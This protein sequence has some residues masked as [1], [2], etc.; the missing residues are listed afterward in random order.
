MRRIRWKKVWKDL[1]SN[2]S[3]TILVVLS[4]AVGVIAIGMVLGAQGI[5]DRQ[6][7]RDFMAI[8]PAAGFTITV[9]NFGDEVVEQIEDLESVGAAEGRRVLITPF[10]TA[11]GEFR[12]LQLVAVP[13]FE[14]IKINKL[15][16]EDGKYPPEKGEILIERS[17]LAPNL[18]F[19]GIEIGDSITVK[20]PNGKER[21]LQIVGTAHDLNNF[22]P[23]LFQTAYGYVSFD[24]MELLQE[25]QEYNQLFYTLSDEFNAQYDYLNLTAAES[26][27]IQAEANRVGSLIQEKIEDTGALVIFTLASPPGELPLQTVLDGLST[28]LLVMGLLSLGL[29]VFLIVNTLSAILTQQVRQIGIMKS[30]GARVPQLTGMYFFMVLI[31][32]VLA[33]IVAI[34]LGALAASG[35][36]Q[37]FALALN[38]NVAG[39]NFDP[40][41]IGLQVVVG[42]SVPLLAAIIP[43]WRGTRTTVREAISDHGG[44]EGNA[45]GTG[46]IDTAI[47]GLKRV[48]PGMKRPAQI[49][50]RNTFRRK[51]RLLLTL[52]SLSLASLIFM[53][54]L[55]IQ[56]SL[57]ETLAESISTFNFD[58]NIR[59]SRDYRSERL[60]REALQN[61]YVT[62]AETWGFSG[63]RRQRPD[64]TESDNIILYGAP[65]GGTMIQPAM[66]A[67]RWLR[68]GDTNAAVVT[69][70][71]LRSEDDLTDA[72]VV[73]QTIMMDINGKETEWVIVGLARGAQPVGIAY[74]PSPALERVTNTVGTAQAVFMRIDRSL[75]APTPETFGQQ[76]QALSDPEGFTQGRPDLNGVAS[77]LE[78]AY[79]DQGFRVEETQTIDLA[80]SIIS[81]FFNIPIYLALVMAALLGFVGGLGLAGTMSINVIE[82]L[83]EI[84]VMRAVGASD[85]SVLGIV[86]LEGVIIGLISWFV[87]AILSYPVSQ[88]LS[89]LA[90]Q[91]LLQA[92]PTYQFSSFGVVLWL[93]IVVLIAIVSSYLPARNASKVTVR[94]VLSY[95]G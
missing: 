95:E 6:L 57:Q 58:L 17:A 29:S 31:F 80:R 62:E 28:L 90:G 7:P 83:R 20:S 23:Q 51:W 84:G 76:M 30:I 55:S 85:R 79:R 70:D 46:I 87:G 67:G 63:G 3:R 82:R 72:N 68:P 88:W 81:L 74:L 94:E 11:P 37:V 59:F 86:L 92:V 52:T 26:S 50:L 49:S 89:N 41:V 71:F 16:P 33:L 54:I 19:N 77:D 60:I 10:E 18:G 13:D 39:F 1:T 45:F 66:L 25:P 4:I 9:T 22:P 15:A 12:N 38:F 14:N 53:S 56:A 64:G 75:L 43:I 2:I 42:L 27:E 35:L 78:T 61:E 8:E 91:L 21:S 32:G 73:G 44:G 40:L 47:L 24:T 5:I 34:P 93:L 65:E 36:A 69:T 48:I